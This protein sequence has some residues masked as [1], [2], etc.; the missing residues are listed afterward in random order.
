MRY[1]ILVHDMKVKAVLYN[2]GNS[3]ELVPHKEMR[4]EKLIEGTVIKL[5]TAGTD[6]VVLNPAGMLLFE[7]AQA[8]E[9][10]LREKVLDFDEQGRILRLAGEEAGSKLEKAREL[11]IPVLNEPE[12]RALCA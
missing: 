12:F 7:F 11:G 6:F 9:V 10:S 8:A 5:L 2:T 3:I 1:K 4:L